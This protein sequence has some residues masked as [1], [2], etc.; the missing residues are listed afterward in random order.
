MGGEGELCVLEL[1]G[2]K[3]RGLYSP[4]SWSRFAPFLEGFGRRNW[5]KG[6][7]E[8]G[9]NW[10]FVYS[11]LAWVR[12]RIETD[13]LEVLCE[14]QTFIHNHNVEGLVS[15]QVT[16]FVQLTLRN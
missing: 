4:P 12:H 10:L 1:G 9:G 14:L 13:F 5:L 8:V 2:R 7:C 3:S 15:Y 16:V 11:F 6:Y